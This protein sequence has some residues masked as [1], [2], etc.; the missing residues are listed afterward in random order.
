MTRLITVPLLLIALALPARAE[1]VTVLADVGIA[2]A[3]HLIHGAFVTHKM[4]IYGLKISVLGIITREVIQKYKHRVPQKYR[5]MV[6]RMH[7]ARI[8]PFWYLPDTLIISPKV[9]GQQMYGI[10]FRPIGL[11][12]ALGRTPRLGLDASLLLTYAYYQSDLIDGGSETHFLRPGIGVRVDVE[13]PITRSFL[14][15]LG[16]QSQFYVPQA[17]GS[18][19]VSPDE[20]KDFLSNTIWHI[21]QG[22]LMFHFRFPYT[23]NI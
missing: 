7:E 23:T 15:S 1:Q 13:F 9:D 10:T 3:V 16:W 4:P 19:G 14:M 21:G 6:D 20:G 2:P 18:F 11:G 8:R 22:Y 12:L 5:G 17:F